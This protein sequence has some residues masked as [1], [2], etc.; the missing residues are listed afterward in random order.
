[1][2]PGAQNM[3]PK[4]GRLGKASGCRL[5]S[6]LLCVITGLA[7]C[8]SSPQ[9]KEAQFLKRGREFLKAK[10]YSRAILEFRNAA[11]VMP[12]DAEPY[13]QL[14]MTALQTENFVVAYSSFQRAVERNAKHSEAQLNLAA[15]M[16]AS[17]DGAMAAEGER[18]LREIAHD[19][20]SGPTA[21]DFLA[22]A[23]LRIG[24]PG[25]AETH[26][27]EALAAFPG[28]LR[29]SV[30]LA[31]LKL[32]KQDLRGA[33]DVLKK[34]VSNAPQSAAAALALGQ[35]YV[36]AQKTDQAEEE[37]HRALQLEPT[38]ASALLSLGSL[39]IAAGKMEEAERTYERLASLP[40]KEFR[41]L[42]AILM[43]QEGKRD[44]ALEEFIKLAKES[45]H[46]R[47]ARSRLVG[48][49]LAMDRTPEA[50]AILDE[51][52]HRNPKDADALLQRSQIYLWAKRFPEAQRDISEALQF[53]PDLALA[54]FELANIERAQGQMQ[55]ARQEFGEALHRAPDFLPARLA[56]ARSLLGAR[57]ARSAA[58]IL[59]QAPAQQ[60]TDP[61]L[62]I[63]TNWAQLALGNTAEFRHGVE[64]GLALGRHPEL[65]LQQGLVKMNM[66]DFTGA[67]A[68]AEEVLRLIPDDIRAARLLVDSF[69]IQNQTALAL[70]KLR[71]LVE[72][73]PQS[74]ALQTLLGNW[75]LAM[76]RPA[77]A[78][79][80]LTR[81]VAANPEYAP[82]GLA[83]AELNLAEGDLDTA[84][85]EAQILAKSNPTDVAVLLLIGRIKERAGDREA[86]LAGYRAVLQV[87]SSNLDALNSLAYSLAANKP[88][89]ALSYAQQAL[90]L[91]PDNPAVQDTLGWVYF[92]KKFYNQAVQYLESAVRREPTANRKL[93]LA[94]AYIASGN[95][96]L[97]NRM[98]ESAVAED[99][100]LRE[101][102]RAIEGLARSPSTRAMP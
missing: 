49:Y 55:H 70:E 42:H 29:S 56:L 9:T 100:K 87:D 86:A 72:A 14:G 12:G 25:E 85:A 41:P 37:F 73:R 93:H 88:D 84:R 91:A 89:E 43:F 62:I 36:V 16:A 27:E 50:A 33:E 3:L 83:L 5:A 44:R 17:G 45:P 39:E 15:L 77:E 79:A 13:Y 95:S 28:H 71:G 53:K 82:G 20:S 19:P 63:E 1:M 4:T 75:L 90:E 99:P 97:G 46:D 76:R 68:N 102:K 51:A 24:R 18:R 67:R 8:S 30:E 59:D 92:S 60:K 48:I 96:V 22:L 98:L 6:A 66:R 2:T 61:S 58:D 64:R 47:D 80:A 7:G 101:S 35:L 11:K 38:N 23:E 31:R 81:A 52:L 54:H 78:R 32:R 74:A 94:Q 10:D 69:A 57:A 65:V 21:L 40:E 34:A 26:L